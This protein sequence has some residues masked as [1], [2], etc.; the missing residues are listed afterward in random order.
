[1]TPDERHTANLA[2]LDRLEATARAAAD[3]VAGGWWWNGADAE[4]PAEHHIA[5]QH[6][7]AVLAQLAGRQRILER[8][9]PKQVEGGWENGAACSD[10]CD[11]WPCPD[12]CDAA[13][14]LPGMEGS[15]PG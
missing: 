12:Y 7:Q 8:H 9:A 4:S 1:M 5:A 15:Q 11:G 10:W 3:D 14:G 13:A 2:A 6:P